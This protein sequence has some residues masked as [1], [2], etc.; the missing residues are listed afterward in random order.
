MTIRKLFLHPYFG[1]RPPWWD[2]YVAQLPAMKEMG[3]D[4]LI[5]HDLKDFH[6]RALA[7]TG[8]EP[9]GLYGTRKLCD[10]RPLLGLLY[11]EEIKKYDFWGFSDA[12]V[13][14]GRVDKWVTDE[15]LSGLD[16]H[17]N[18]HS[19][20]CGPWT[21][22]RVGQRTQDLF[23]EVPDWREN[24]TGTEL[25]G[26]AETSFS[27]ALENSGLRYEYTYWQTKNLDDF[28]TLT[29][30]EDG[31]LLEGPNEIMCAHFRRTKT[32]PLKDAL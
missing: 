1:E 21:L 19:Y 24:L 10:W 9:Q 18:H 4:F 26:W 5:T 7:A 22:F 15:F 17:S 29:R 12:D 14:Y 30:R 6:H 3:Y 32:W 23:L 13:A 2:Q 11:A 25:T 31:A 16:V 28:S 8:I 20:V 27:R